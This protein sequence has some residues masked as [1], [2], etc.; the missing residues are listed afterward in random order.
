MKKE[1]QPD[2]S[3]FSKNLTKYREQRYKT[4]SEFYR[5]FKNEYDER[6]E[7]IPSYMTYVSYENGHRTPKL[8]TIVQLAQFLSVPLDLFLGLYDEN[9]LEQYIKNTLKGYKIYRL[10]NN[11]DKVLISNDQ[12]QIAWIS[13]NDFID[14]LQKN[15]YE[16]IPN[17]VT[18]FINERIDEAV[19]N[20]QMKKLEQV[21]NIATYSIAKLLDINTADYDNFLI[22]LKNQKKYPDDYPRLIF[23]HNPILALSFYYFTGCRPD[24]EIEKTAKIFKYLRLSRTQET[25]PDDLKTLDIQSALSYHPKS[26]NTEIEKYFIAYTFTD[27]EKYENMNFEQL[28]RAFFNVFLPSYLLK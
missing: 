14:Y 1:K 26:P 17:K 28:K 15:V 25:I 27:T 22:Q 23:L 4:A 10:K 5:E 8:E 2:R 9:Y 24:L 7:K 18:T 16:E 12:Q 20:D 11:K 19:S 3:L 6:G 21:A 13:I